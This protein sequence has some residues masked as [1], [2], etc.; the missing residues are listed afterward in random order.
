M[1]L[2]K[3]QLTAWAVNKTI[4]GLAH[5]CLTP[6]N[7]LVT[8]YWE[9]LPLAITVTVI[10]VTLHDCARSRWLYYY[11]LRDSI[12]VTVTWLHP[13]ELR[14]S[15]PVT[16]TWLHPCDS[17]VAPSLWRLRDSIPVTVTWLRTCDSYVTP[18]LWQ[19]RDSVPV[20]VTWLRPCDSYVTPSLWQLRDSI[21]VAVTWLHPCDSYVTP[22]L[23]QLRDSIPVTVTWLH[24]C[25]SY[26]TPSLWQLRDSIPVTVTWLHPCGCKCDFSSL[27]W[28]SMW[29][30]YCDGHVTITVTLSVTVTWP[31]ITVSHKTPLLWRSHDLIAVTVNIAFQYCDSH[32]IP[33]PTV[34]WLPFY[35]DPH[36][37]PVGGL[38]SISGRG[39]GWS[40][41]FFLFL[42]ISQGRWKAIFVYLRIDCFHHALWPFIYFTH[43]FHK[44][45]FFK[46]NSNPLVFYDGAPPP[47]CSSDV[48]HH[49]CD[50]DRTTV[51]VTGTG[52]GVGGS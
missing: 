42:F 3:R 18:S 14:D 7:D 1:S 10:S 5:S 43:F 51:T 6:L 30:H 33:W 34:T 41:Y 25:D 23:W 38:L 47:Y 22:S 35:C 39:G 48:T 52:S 11:L 17:Y 20:A 50:G 32:V 21:P 2:I 19:L 49:V 16:V 4:P 15:I 26:V 24:P 46:K 9:S 27:L 44:T 45:I 31:C 36:V 12:P 29:L 13:C 37:T 8:N 40:F 28:E